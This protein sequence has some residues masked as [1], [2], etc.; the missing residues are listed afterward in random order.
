MP[1]GRRVAPLREEEQCAW[2]WWSRLPSA[3]GELAC[4]HLF[5]RRGVQVVPPIA[6]EVRAAQE[7]RRLLIPAPEPRVVR[8]KTSRI[9]TAVLLPFDLGGHAENTGGS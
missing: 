2:R 4:R 1:P 5:L 8:L 7:V 3:L 6:I 9:L